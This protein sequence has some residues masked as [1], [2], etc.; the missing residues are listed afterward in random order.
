M[1]VAE[2]AVDHRRIDVAE[3]TA[4]AEEVEAVAVEAELLA[5]RHGLGHEVERGTDVAGL[6]GDRE[7]HLARVHAS[8]TVLRISTIRS[9]VWL[10]SSP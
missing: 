5:A 1:E 4:A 7:H 3:H 10:A 9:A 6:L 8:C 2:G